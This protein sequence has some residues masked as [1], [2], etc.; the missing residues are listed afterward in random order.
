MIQKNKLDII[1]NLW[2]FYNQDTWA[3]QIMA[4]SFFGLLFESS[5]FFSELY[6]IAVGI[7]MHD[8]KNRKRYPRLMRMSLN[9]F[10]LKG[11][12]NIRKFF[13]NK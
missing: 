5:L 1:S 4:A 9:P 11:I 10:N 13:K 8:W 2:N 6:Y 12:S 7:T 3:F